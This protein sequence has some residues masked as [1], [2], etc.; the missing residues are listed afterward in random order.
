MTS[1]I[2]EKR[3]VWVRMIQAGRQAGG[4]TGSACV[5]GIEEHINRSTLGLERWLSG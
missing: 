1:R 2:I 3:S 5:L 4:Q